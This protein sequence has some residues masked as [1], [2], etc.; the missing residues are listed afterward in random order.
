MR[1]RVQKRHSWTNE[2]LNILSYLRHTHHWG[3][4]QIQ[5][6]YF[7]TLTPSALRG[8]YWYLSIEDRIR[9]ASR[10]IIPGFPTAAETQPAC[11]SIEQGT[12]RYSGSISGNLTRSGNSTETLA[13]TAQSPAGEI[14]PFTSNNCNS[15]RYE[16]RPNRPST[17]PPKEPQ[18]FVDRHHFPH[19][20]RSYQYSFDLRELSDSDYTPPSRTLTPSSSDRSV[21]LISSLPSAASSLEL[22]GLEV[23][24]LRSSDRESATSGRPNSVSSSEFF[25]AEETPLPK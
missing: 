9:R 16:L 24:S 20:F 14:E 17:F 22:F 11:F 7:P 15:S 13:S 8:A 12:G 5:T 25:S 2:E 10:I 23:R 18:Y 1:G 19:F 3:F 4:K 6:T 21:S